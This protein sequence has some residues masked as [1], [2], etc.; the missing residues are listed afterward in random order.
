MFLQNFLSQQVLA[1]QTTSG[2]GILNME[3]RWIGLAGCAQSRQDGK[4]QLYFC[5][6]K[7]Y[8]GQRFFPNNLLNNSLLY[9]PESWLNCVPSIHLIPNRTISSIY[10][11]KHFTEM[12][13][14]KLNGIW[15]PQFRKRGSLQLLPIDGN[16]FKIKE[17]KEKSYITT[18]YL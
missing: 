15:K 8:R 18:V 9:D 3:Q 7:L 14:N 5:Y 16:Y 10:R 17:F 11:R 2:F 12:R 13:G 4:N 1:V 6:F